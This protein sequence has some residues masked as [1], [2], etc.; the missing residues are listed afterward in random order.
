MKKLL[1]I[2]T[3]IIGVFLDVHQEILT[4]VLTK[5]VTQIQIN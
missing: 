2:G 4:Q 5:E 1:I 3:F